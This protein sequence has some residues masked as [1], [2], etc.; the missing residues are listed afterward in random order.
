MRCLKVRKVDGQVALNLL[1]KLGLIHPSFRIEQLGMYIIIPLKKPLNGVHRDVLIP[2]LN[3]FEEVEC[4]PKVM[5][6]RQ[7]PREILLAAV[8]PDLSAYVPRSI[9]TIGH[10]AVVELPPKLMGCEAI[11][12]AILNTYKKVK[13]VL[14]KVGSTTGNYRLKDYKLLAGENKT[15]T[16]YIEHKCR[17]M[18]D[19]RKVYFNPRLSF[20]RGRVASQVQSGEVIVDM[21][22]GVGPFSILIAKRQRGVKV[23]SIDTNPSAFT[24]L[25]EN[26]FLNRVVGRV[27]PMQG[28]ARV[29]VESKL[30]GKADRVIMNLP[31][32]SFEYLPSASKALKQSG[33]TIHFYCFAREPN[34]TA[35]AL[36]GLEDVT[37]EIQGKIVDVANI[38]YV[39]SIAPYLWMIGLDLRVRPQS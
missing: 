34:P 20:E 25:R 26:I 16:I 29:L 2:E 8:P 1:K 5:S 38:R 28:D 3:F 35:V 17:Y 19:L 24:Y 13:T 4:E 7:D 23:Y 18:L 31:T 12:D 15:E 27:I 32:R 6:R 39:R 21:F 11:G 36:K 9:D 10:I 33:G 37:D 22:A 14:A 30:N